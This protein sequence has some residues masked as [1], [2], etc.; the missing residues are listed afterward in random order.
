MNQVFKIQ[1]TILSMIGLVSYF[2]ENIIRAFVLNANGFY[3]S[4]IA[5]CMG[6][7]AGIGIRTHFSKI[8]KPN[9]LGKVFSALGA[10]DAIAPLIASAIFTS[11]FNATLD[12]IPGLTLLVVALVLVIPFV[13]MVWIHFFTV[14]P[15]SMANIEINVNNSNYGTNESSNELNV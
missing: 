2:T 15:D 4:L 5:G 14:L 8:I 11:I 10:M 12:T 3:Y 13:V 7:V 9:E 1:D 6:S